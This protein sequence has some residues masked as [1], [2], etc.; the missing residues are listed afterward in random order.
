[1][2]AWITAERQNAAAQ[3]GATY[4]SSWERTSLPLTVSAAY[5]TQFQAFSA[6]FKSEMAAIGDDTLSQEATVLDKLAQ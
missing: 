4:D 6:Y 2:K 1:M 5:R 3:A